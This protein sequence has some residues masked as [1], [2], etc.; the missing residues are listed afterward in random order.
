[1]A[2]TLTRSTVCFAAALPLLAPALGTGLA[3][4]ASAQQTGPQSPPGVVIAT[5]RSLADGTPL[6]ADP[7]TIRLRPDAATGAA[8]AASLR[9]GAGVDAVSGLPVDLAEQARAGW[10]SY[11]RGDT[12]AARVALTGPASHPAAP[13]WVPYVLGWSAFAEDDVA[14]ARAQWERVRSAVPDFLPVY[15]NIADTYLRE[16]K[17]P[18]ALVVLAQAEARWPRNVDVLNAA[19]VV[20]AASGRLGEAIAAFTR[21]TAAEPADPTGHFNLGRA[22]EL[23]FVDSMLKGGDPGAA[24]A[25]RE[26]AIVEYRLVRNGPLAEAAR[27]GLGRLEPL[28]AAR[29]GFSPGK[30]LV[31]GGEGRFGG[32]PARLA[33]SPDSTRLL[34]RSV[35]RDAKGALTS[36][37]LHLI[38]DEGRMEGIAQAPDWAAQ[39]WDWKSGLEAPWRPESRL[40]SQERMV[41]TLPEQLNIFTSGFTRD[42]SRIPKQVPVTVHHF[43][44]EEVAL[45]TDP[46]FARGSTFSWAPFAQGALAFRD[47]RALLVIM[48]SEGRKR[49]V[50][51][52]M[53][54]L[55]PAWSPNGRR[56]AFVVE[57]RGYTVVVVELTVK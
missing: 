26:L 7:S 12:K 30:V 18:D 32:T 21:A 47:R 13:P 35:K 40:T 43:L 36:D 14:G 53:H 20:Q 41:A 6:P 42:Y 2:C 54:G 50:P 4:I 17:R 49:D 52:S 25:D 56:L 34:L 38:V 46:L 11:Q 48:D 10:E 31:K 29:L 1:M 9:G 27:A 57:D 39:Y 24:T 22:A 16:L 5:T 44:E 55:L 45:I 28:D 3:A 37:T 19:G 51:D 15:L 8:D 23:R 33:W